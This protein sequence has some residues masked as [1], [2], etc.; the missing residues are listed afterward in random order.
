MTELTRVWCFA[1][2]RAPWVPPVRGPGAFQPCYE[3]PWGAESHAL[4]KLLLPGAIGALFGDDGV[5]NSHDPV[6]QASMQA[7]AV[8]GQSALAGRFAPPGVQIPLALFPRQAL[9]PALPDA[10]AFIVIVGVVGAP[11]P[12]HPALETTDGLGIGGQLGAQHL[13]TWGAFSRHDSE[14]GGS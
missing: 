11:L 3:H 1:W 10:S 12:V 14:R 5:P 9:L 7:L 2:E 4:A 6:D 13:Q 8:R